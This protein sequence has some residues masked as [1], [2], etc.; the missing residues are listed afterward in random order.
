MFSG[1]LWLRTGRCGVRGIGEEIAK[2]NPDII[3]F[4]E[5]FAKR[6]RKEILAGLEKAGWGKP[7]EFYENHA[8]GPGVWIVSK[9]P[10]EKAKNFTYPLNGTPKDSDWY[11]QKSVAYARV[12]TPFGPVDL[13]DT[14]FIARYTDTFDK[15][16]KLVEDDTSKTDRLCQADFMAT[17][18]NQ[19]AKENQDRSIIAVGDFNSEPVLLEY[20][21]F[22]AI[23]GLNNVVYELPIQNCTAKEP[24]CN[25]DRR[26]DDVF[27]Q[28]YSDGSGF[29]LKPVSA[30][31]VLYTKY[32][33]KKGDLR[34]S[35]HNGL[36]VDFAVLTSDDAGIK[37][38]S[39]DK[40]LVML[41]NGKRPVVTPAMKNDLAAGK[42]IAG[43]PDWVAFCVNALDQLNATRNR[44]NKIPT[45]AAKILSARPGSQVTLD[46]KDIDE[47]KKAFDMFSK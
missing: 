41:A 16:G 8:Y 7:Y 9:Y 11:A 32:P 33:T 1:C 15:Q 23:A 36:I 25:L 37:P 35:D 39:R 24:D 43:D 38:V 34:L 30:E 14:H 31:L 28:N 6:Q 13:F 26:I 47:V 18:I 21:L 4:Q 12:K 17:K 45:A 46:P 2:L 42:I 5:A 29:F 40:A 3:G 44:K 10:I 19:T 22:N 27:Y 20:K